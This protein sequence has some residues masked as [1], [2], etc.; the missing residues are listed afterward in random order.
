MDSSALTTTVTACYFWVTSHFTVRVLDSTSWYFPISA[1]ML[2]QGHF[3]SLCYVVWDP[4]YYLH[5]EKWD[6][7]ILIP[8]LKH[9]FRSHEGVSYC[10][11][12]FLDVPLSL[13]SLENSWWVPISFLL[14]YIWECFLKLVPCSDVDGAELCFLRR[15]P[16]RKWYKMHWGG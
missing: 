1:S 15:H 11:V 16:R 3:L 4:Q 10:F 8:S 12:S 14:C 9:Q 7:I 13:Q 6:L 5:W 2:T